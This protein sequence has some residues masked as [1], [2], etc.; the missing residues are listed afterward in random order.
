MRP[1]KVNSSELLQGM[2]N[3]F[4][5]KGYEGASLN[6]LATSSGLQKASLYHRFPNGKKEIATAVLN[7]VNE[8]LQKDLCK[9]LADTTTPSNKRIIKV[10]ENINSFYDGGKATCLLRSISLNTGMELF[11]TEIKDNMN[12]WINAFTNFG[13]EIGFS[14]ATALENAK[15]TLITIQGSLVVS[16]GLG[17]Y[18]IFKKALSKIEHIYKG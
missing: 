6:D 4:R 1:Q 16:K 3:V 5:S 15:E 17:D 14:E 11:G 10:I 7:Y 18:T 2:L 12:E 13:K 9:I 8:G